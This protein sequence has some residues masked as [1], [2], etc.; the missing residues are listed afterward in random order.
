[1]TDTIQTV[2]DTIPVVNLA[3]DTVFNAFN[4]RVLLSDLSAGLSWIMFVYAMIGVLL[5]FLTKLIYSTNDAKKNKV[6]FHFLNWL[7]ENIV[8][9]AVAAL[10]AIL[11]LFLV[12]EYWHPVTVGKSAIIGFAGG[13]LVFNVYPVVTSP[14]TWKAVW[15]FL[16]ERFKPK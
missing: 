9:L 8:Y 12:D 1:M 16:T 15:A 11:L 14:G 5:H 6:P 13:S 3:G 7:G 4:T 10:S 2:T